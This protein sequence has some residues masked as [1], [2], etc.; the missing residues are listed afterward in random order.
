MASLTTS[1]NYK[2]GFLSC[3]C[4]DKLFMAYAYD[5]EQQ[6]LPLTF[7]IVV[8]EKNITNWGWFMQWLHKEVVGPGKIAVISDQHLGIRIVFERPDFE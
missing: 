4:V 1:L 8:G 2:V 7:T 6:L 3:W 5:A